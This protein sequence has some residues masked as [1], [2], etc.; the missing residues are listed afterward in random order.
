LNWSNVSV[1]ARPRERV[2]QERAYPL[3]HRGRQGQ[4]A[5]E[6]SGVD[7]YRGRRQAPAREH[8]RQQA[9]GRVPYDRWFLVQGMDDLGGVIGDLLQGLVGQHVRFRPGLFNRF[10]IIGPVRRQRRVPGLLEEVRPAGPAARQ[11]PQAVD[12]HDRGVARGIGRLDF[13]VL[14][15][16][17]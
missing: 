12:E 7:R 4:N 9:P 2:D 13:L 1:I 11:Q 3:E 15:L 17:N 6:D 5:A 16:R 10:R 14:P 8:L